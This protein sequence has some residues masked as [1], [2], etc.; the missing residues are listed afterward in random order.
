M[1]NHH[2][3]C[4][5][6]YTSPI[7]V[8]HGANTLTCAMGKELQSTNYTTLNTIFSVAKYICLAQY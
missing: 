3:M 4:S 5:Q 8:A 7:E 2:G 6:T 1:W